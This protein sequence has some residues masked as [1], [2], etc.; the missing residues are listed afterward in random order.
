MLK[1]IIETI[2]TMADDP[3]KYRAGLKRK[4]LELADSMPLTQM[5]PARETKVRGSCEKR[6][7]VC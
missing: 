5:D 2:G 6:L 4:L 1:V 3:D 7:T